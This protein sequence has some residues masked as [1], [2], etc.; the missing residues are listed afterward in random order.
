[1]VGFN[2]RFAPATV[3][4]RKAIGGRGPV[5][6]TIRV[7]AGRI[8]AGN[9]VH[10]PLVGGGRIVGEG[11]HFVDLAAA[12]AGCEP[13]GVEAA[14]IGTASGRRDDS[15]GATV[16]LAD[17]S[18][19]T[20]LY[21][22]IGDPALPKERIEVLSEVGAAVIDDFKLVELYTGGRVDR[23]ESKRDKGHA[24]EIA[25]FLRQCTTG[26]QAWPV[27]EMLAVSDMALR[28]RESVTGS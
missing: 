11:C 2:R 15:F 25:A 3:A 10:D 18:V 6:I 13:V 28:I 1:M 16:R 9:W 5:M 20:I 24:A 22:A 19:A 12:I 17:G 26:E 14:A 4:V 7:N 23:S 21:S 8:P 27:A